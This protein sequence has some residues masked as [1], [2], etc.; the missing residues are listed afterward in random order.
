VDEPL[1]ATIT[2]DFAKF[3]LLWKHKWDF[4]PNETLFATLVHYE[5]KSVILV[6]IDF[7]LN[8]TLFCYIGTLWKQKWD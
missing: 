6:E 2:V 5:S 4:A 8:K 7:A 3:E 1:F